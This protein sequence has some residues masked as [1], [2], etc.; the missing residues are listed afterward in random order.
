MAPFSLPAA[1]GEKRK[2]NYTTETHFIQAIAYLHIQLG[3]KVGT[4]MRTIPR[5]F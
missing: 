1:T 4:G 2:Q 3:S 5:D